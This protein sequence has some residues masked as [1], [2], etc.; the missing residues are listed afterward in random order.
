MNYLAHAYLAGND[1]GLII[2]NYL[3]DGMK[4]MKLE[5]FSESIQRGVELHRHIDSYTDQHDQVR[6]SK[7][8]LYERHGH[9]ASVIVDVFYDHFLAKDWLKYSDKNLFN[10]EKKIYSLLIDNKEV[11]PKH[12]KYFLDYMVEQNLLSNYANIKTIG[13]TLSGLA[14]RT[15]FESNMAYA[16]NDLRDQYNGFQEDFDLFFPD[17]ER[18]VASFLE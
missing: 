1:H 12:S 2:G 5:S 8:R 15:K 11:L 7:N 14:R 6:V 17:L 9:Y 16:V 18:S 3:A 10:F 13:D 4:G